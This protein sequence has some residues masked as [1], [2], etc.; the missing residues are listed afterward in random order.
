M[1]PATG[2]GGT[3]P[4]FSDAELDRLQQLLDRVPA[5]FEAL[6]VSMLDGFLCGV[7]VQ[8]TRIAEAQWLPLITDVEGRPLPKGFDAA[9]LHQL[10][11]RR[12]RELDAAI[13]ARRWFDP[14]VFELDLDAAAD[15]PGSDDSD[16][17]EAPPEVNA[18]YPWVAGFVTALDVFPGLMARSGPALDDALIL[19][20]RHLDP[21]DFE[22]ADEML[23]AIEA[24]EPAQNL[25]VA[26]EELVRA[27]LLLADIG[28]PLAAPRAG[29]PAN[30][31]RP[32]AAGK[33]R[34]RR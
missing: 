17:D 10:A 5:P 22:D 4:P 20:Y 19:L 18:V 28:R 27:T 23:L 15:E 25:T 11:R 31:P 33:G 6:D 12:H 3:A 16:P 32:G 13:G 9:P 34:P 24:L 14:W 7:L 2:S 21:D 26:V 30:R 1:K 8:P 29:R